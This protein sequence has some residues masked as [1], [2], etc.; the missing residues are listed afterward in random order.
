MQF[1]SRIKKL[2]INFQFIKVYIMLIPM[3]KIYIYTTLN[4]TF[5]NMEH[6]KESHPRVLQVLK[7]LG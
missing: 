3:H 6:L 4:V 7:I 1:Y 5:Q 2:S